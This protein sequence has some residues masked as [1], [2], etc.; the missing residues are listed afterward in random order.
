MTGRWAKTA[1]IFSAVTGIIA[2]IYLVMLIRM[3][4][5]P[6]LVLF[7]LMAIESIVLLRGGLIMNDPD[8][9][10]NRRGDTKFLYAFIIILILGGSAALATTSLHTHTYSTLQEGSV[11]IAMVDEQ[12]TTFK[13]KM[14]DFYYLD[15]DI[16][17]P[18][19][20]TVT[21]KDEDG[22]TVFTKTSTD[23]HIENMRLPLSSG[24]YKLL[25][26]ASSR[27]KVDFALD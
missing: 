4:Q 1:F 5:I 27:F 14:P 21:I 15:L 10:R 9:N 8:A 19:P 16:G 3:P 6:Y 23:L 22:E 13:I 26:S 25:L 2:L 18:S 17:S 24:D 12:W 20:V 7:L 11:T